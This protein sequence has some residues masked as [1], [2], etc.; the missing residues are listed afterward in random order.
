MLCYV[1]CDT[2]KAHGRRSTYVRLYESHDVWEKNIIGM[3]LIT[4]GFFKKSEN[5]KNELKA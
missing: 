2:I 4:V 1:C 3:V 5:K